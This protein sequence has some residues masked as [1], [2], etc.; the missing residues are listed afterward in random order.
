MEF[1]HLIV[2]QDVLPSRDL[3]FH[4]Q[5]VRAVS[6][7]LKLV[8]HVKVANI[9]S[10]QLDNVLIVAQEE[11]SVKEFIVTLHAYQEHSLMETI[12]NSVH[13]IVELAKEKLITVLAA[14]EMLLIS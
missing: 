1:A 7:L 5:D 3:V 4:V 6:E 8:H 9:S 2:L 12:V 13:Q 11:P 10:S 14:L